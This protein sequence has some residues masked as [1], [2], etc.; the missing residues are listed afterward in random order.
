MLEINLDFLKEATELSG[1]FFG[2]IAAI[3]SLWAILISPKK[4]AHVRDNLSSIWHIIEHSSAID[5]PKKCIRLALNSIYSVQKFLSQGYSENNYTAAKIS[6]LVFFVSAI[7]IIVWIKY[8]SGSPELFKIFLYTSITAVFLRFLLAMLMLIKLGEP[9]IHEYRK[10][11]NDFN[12]Y[13]KETDKTIGLYSFACDIILIVPVL[14]GYSTSVM[15]A[16]KHSSALIGAIV[17][18]VLIPFGFLLVGLLSGILKMFAKLVFK[19]QFMTYERMANIRFLGFAYAIS[20]VV[21]ILAIYVGTL[22]SQSDIDPRTVQMLISNVL[23]DGLTLIVTVSILE[24]AIRTIN[25]W[26]IVTAIFFDLILAGVFACA[27]LWFGVVGT[28]IELSIGETLY[29]LI[30]QHPAT[31]E[32]D[33]SPFFFVM[34]TVF[35]PTAIYLVLILISWIAKVVAEVAKWSLV[36]FSRDELNPFALTA[37]LFGVLT[38]VFALFSTALKYA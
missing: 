24:R 1:V 22:T 8:S 25:P 5:L 4:L 23:F 17:L 6:I 19:S 12:N 10:F 34:H 3:F 36:L 35:I 30:G 14:L 16:L 20:F 2:F 38:T 33:F 37:A 29:I 27:S 28:E 31:G 9:F 18:L 21:T 15:L 7:I 32:L 11:I 13:D 26:P